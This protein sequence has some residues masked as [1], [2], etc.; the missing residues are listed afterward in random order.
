MQEPQVPASPGSPDTRTKTLYLLDVSSFIFR[1]FFAIRPLHTR[2]GEPSNAVYGVATMLARLFD[3]ANPEY[4]AVTYDSKGQSFRKELYPEYK[5][6]R[7]APPDDLI[8]QFSRID[9]LISAL[10][11]PSCRQEGVEA[12]DLIASLTRKWL[13]LSPD[14]QVVIVTGDKDLMQLVDGRVRIWDTMN[15]RFYGSPEVEAKFGV[16]PGQIRDYLALVGDSS[17]NIPGVAGVGPKTAVDLLKQFGSLDGILAAAEQGKVPGKRGETLRTSVEVARLSAK[18]ATVR[19]DLDIPLEF[20]QLKYSF[21]VTEAVVDLLQELNFGSLLERWR[22]KFSAPPVPI[23]EPE[24]IPEL[25]QPEGLFRTINTEKDFQD[26][27]E[28]LERT[29]EFGFD[30]ETTSLNPREAELVGFAICHDPAFGCYI[31]VGHRGTSVPQLPLERVVEGLKPYLEDPRYKKIGQNLKYD[32]SVLRNLGLKPDGIGADTMVAG[33]VLNAEGRFNLQVLADKYLNYRVMTFEE[34]CGKGKDQLCFDQVPID[35][36]TRYSAEDAWISMRLWHDLRIKLDKE[37]LME[38]FARVDLP[39]VR[40]L[41]RMEEAGV[42]IDVQWLKDL[43]RE[44]DRELLEIE[45]RIHAFTRGPINLN[46]PKQLAVLLFDELRLP[47]QGKTKTGY[48][49]DASV[50][51]ALAPLHEVPKLLLEY[52]EIAKLKGTYVDPLP[53]L[54]DS[55]TGRIHASFHQAVTA[56][57]RLS[58]SDPNLQNIPIR[59]ERGRRIRRAFIASPGNVLVSADYSQIELRILAHMSGDA[60]LIHSFRNNEDVHRRTASEIFRVAPE[61]VDDRQRGIA[62]AIN[63]GLMY[64]KT[65]FGLSQELKIPR[66]EAKDIIDRY[67][68]RYSGVKKFLDGLIDEAREKGFAMTL[69]GRKRHLPDISSRNPAVRSNAERMA[70]N[71]PIQGTAADL[72]KLAMIEIDH[73]LERRG[74]RSRLIIQVHDEVVLDCP[75]SEAEEALRIVTEAMEGAARMDVPLSVNA[76]TAKNWMDL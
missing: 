32:W 71:T 6:N 33:Y 28:A 50:L 63:F 59:S 12:D 36:A 23:P 18:L 76:G 15:N 3:D 9:Q 46:S 66:G 19:E 57:G 70:M 1:A 48:S 37:R 55:R 74:M 38:I 52:R 4:F 62:K 13:G 60:D 26:L 69:L 22:A 75:E 61:A 51:E 20:E 53:I 49:T 2:T 41:A 44:F 72:M 45:K 27:L 14:H 56:T 24:G 29:R 65:V 68:Q 67:F 43:S 30:V 34:V 58:S 17:D 64:G 10:E 39:L 16:T 40:V 35:Q 7:S 54:R 5:A 73:Q 31:P 42:S 25:V 8:P 11:I 47:V 21:H